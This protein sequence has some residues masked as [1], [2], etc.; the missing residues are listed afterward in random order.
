MATCATSTVVKGAIDEAMLAAELPPPSIPTPSTGGLTRT[1]DELLLERFARLGDE[2]AFALIV[3]RYTDAVYGTC[4]RVLHDPARADDATQETFFRL[5]RSPGAV[6]QSLG[7]WLHRAATTISIDCLRHEKRLHAWE[8]EHE[9]R[10]QL[11]PTEPTPAEALGWKEIA[12]HVDE[13]LNEL[14]EADRWLLVQHYFRGRAIRALAREIGTSAPTLSRRHQAALAALKDKL[15]SRGVV[16]AAA[17]LA[18]WLAENG[19]VAAPPSVHENLGRLTLYQ[20]ATGTGSLAAALGLTARA[21]SL[22][23][24]LT[25][26]ALIGGLIAATGLLPGRGDD[27]RE[28]AGKPPIV[29]VTNSVVGWLRP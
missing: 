3:Q 8:R 6:E 11:D 23:A 1:S 28:T 14:P 12:P 10:R 25:V 7:G 27:D 15:K 17:L 16:A 5:M 2:K 13:A 26:V 24:V 20:A 21:F 29:Y 9:T 22:I 4:L 18:T 19:A